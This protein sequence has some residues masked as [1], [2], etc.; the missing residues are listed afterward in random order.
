MS[1]L[2]DNPIPE[3]RDLAGVLRELGRVLPN[4]PDI[5]RPGFR[6]RYR[7]ILNALASS[8][9][10]TGH[11]SLLLEG[12]PYFVGGDE[13]RIVR[14][15]Q[16]G[17]DRVYKF[18]HSDS[19]GCRGEF[20]PSDPELSGKHFFA[21]VNTDLFFY[22]ERWIYLNSITA[23]QTRF[24]GFV[25]PE[26][27]RHV[28]RVCISQPL[29]PSQTATDP[30][31]SEREIEEAFLP[32]GYQK[33]SDGAFLHNGSGILLTDAAPR[34]VR[35]VDGA[36]IPFD[37]IAQIASPEVIKWAKSRLDITR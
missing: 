19:F 2:Q 4:R 14:A 24:E 21:G 1:P 13:H 22:L 11:L 26:N 5:D 27:E 37:A 9:P 17:Q 25:P 28:P 32:Y 3:N 35:I 30:N 36:P 8:F 33:I 7:E 16:D 23:F 15:P 10:T 29:L 34:N 12:A 31:P 18:T 20:H 6:G